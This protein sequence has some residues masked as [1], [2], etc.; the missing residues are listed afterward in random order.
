[1]K[2]R[3]VPVDL[4]TSPYI[5]LRQSYTALTITDNSER[6]YASVEAVNYGCYQPIFAP[7]GITNQLIFFE[8][9]DVVNKFTTMFGTPDTGKY[10]P[11]FTY[12][13][14][15][16]KSGFTLGTINIRPQEATYPN[17]YL[18]FNVGAVKD[19]ETG[20]MKMTK[21]YIE[22]EP[23]ED[24]Y[25]MDTVK[26]RLPNANA[27]IEVDFPVM[28]AKFDNYCI[29]G[30]TRDTDIDEYLGKTAVKLDVAGG[31]AITLDDYIHVPII[32]LAY[33]GAGDYNNF[34]AVFDNNQGFLNSVYPIFGCTIYDGTTQK[35]SFNFCLFDIANEYNVNQSFENRATATCKVVFNE[36]TKNSVQEFRPYSV[37]KKVANKLTDAMES[38]CTKFQDDLLRRVK[39]QIPTFDPDASQSDWYNI[40]S[41]YTYLT[42]QFERNAE[43][44][45][46]ET[47]FSRNNPFVLTYLSGFEDSPIE[48]KCASA[49]QRFS[50]GT[51][52]PLA[53][54]LEDEG[55]SFDI[56]L[57][58]PTE[59]DVIILDSLEVASGSVEIGTPFTFT[60]TLST[61]PAA[62]TQ[63]FVDELKK[64]YGGEIDPAVL[65]PSF[66]RD[67][68]I[69][70]E[71]YPNELQ[72][73]IAEFVRYHDGTINY[74]GGRCD[75]TY[76]R[77]PPLS[78]TTIDE[79]IEWAQ[80]FGTS[81]NMNMH[82]V[83]GRWSFIDPSTGSSEKFSAFFDYLGTNG[84][85]YNY[86]TSYTPD[87]IASGSYSEVISGA[88]NTQ[89]LVPKTVAN[90]ETLAKADVMFYAR[91]SNGNYAL[92][93]DSAHI[94]NIDSVMKNIGSGIHFNKMINRLYCFARDNKI[95][96]ATDENLTI[97]KQKAWNLISEIAAAFNNN[98]TVTTLLSDHEYEKDSDVVLFQLNVI[99]HNYS[100]H[101]RIAAIIERSSS[102]ES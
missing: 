97:L 89:E 54:I 93:E 30:L 87:S 22:Y 14:Q 73:H 10:G 9:N 78:V 49:V 82:T 64:C 80:S 7:K 99:G 48:V 28:E 86:L 20:K 100:R 77:T 61:E 27:I 11:M 47:P 70:G 40:I 58:V 45:S 91:K 102:T 26:S 43:Y 59:E 32:G 88:E 4:I 83:I 41:Y 56:M 3:I 50:G 37:S 23:D 12:A 90:R 67:A 66:M 5:S 6:E 33:R 69:F 68:I 84:V 36:S 1:M 15:I 16:L 31:D 53:K 62:Q 52:G 101:N 51:M 38:L 17:F 72:E 39:E 55:F 85:L 98:V 75:M 65:D 60:V 34:R 71:W 8:G 35:Y 18:G 42:A 94:P 79:A 81:K 25:H 76:I 63:F 44:R 24:Y 57:D 96:D 21:L 19:D 74:D 2:S 92:S 95:I 13:L 46:L 29:D